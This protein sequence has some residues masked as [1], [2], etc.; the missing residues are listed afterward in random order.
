MA[1]VVD[2]CNLALAR[3]GDRATVSSIDPPE[4]SAQADHCARFYPLARDVALEE[5]AWTF[6]TSREKLTETDHLAAGWSYSYFVPNDCI[7]VQH[8]TDEG[9]V[10]KPHGAIYDPEGNGQW[11]EGQDYPFEIETDANGR[12]VI[13]TNLPDA[14]VVFTTRACDPSRWSSR[15]IDALVFLLASYLAG[16][17]LKGRTG[18]AATRS[19]Y[20]AYRNVVGQA[21]AR[22]ANQSNHKRGYTPQG[23]AARGVHFNRNRRVG[24]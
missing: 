14:Y 2:I 20:A 5:T 17:V 24:Y 13:V 12:E 22:N 8:L 15:F 18:E 3:L 11:I 9:Y 6:A 19:M 10:V 1:T 7:H 16:P 23:M 21:S 4:G